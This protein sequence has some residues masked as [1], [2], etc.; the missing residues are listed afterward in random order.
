MF[1]T[2]SGM[3][4]RTSIA[5][6]STVGRNTQGVRLVNLKDGDSLVSVEIIS[7]ADLERFADEHAE[8]E[9]GD[10]DLDAGSSSPDDAAAGDPTDASGESDPETPAED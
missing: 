4:V 8:G 3:I 9:A 5:D 2:E 10:G 7:S 6:I 1:I